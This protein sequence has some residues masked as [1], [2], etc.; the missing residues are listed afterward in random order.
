[1]F[2]VRQSFSGDQ[3]WLSHTKTRPDIGKE[4]ISGKVSIVQYNCLGSC[5]IRTMDHNVP[6][7]RADFSLNCERNSLMTNRRALTVYTALILL[8]AWLGFAPVDCRAEQ[9]E[10]LTDQLDAYITKV[11]DLDIAPGLAVAVVEGSRVVYSK[12]FGYADRERG[13]GVTP[14]TMFYIG[15]TTKSFTAFA[16]LLL[17]HRGVF[18]L[19]KPLSHYLPQVKLHSPLSAEEITI[20]N[21]LTHTH[22][23]DNDGP[24]VFRSALTGEYNRDELM[25]LL[26]VHKP[27][28]TGKSF[29]YGNIGYN[30]AGFAMEA[31]TGLSWK[32]VLHA[33][34]FDPLGLKSTTSYASKVDS[35]S[36]AMPYEIDAVGSRRMAYGK[37]DANMHA[38][39]GHLSTVSDLARWLLVHLNEGL[40]DGRQVFPKEI[41]AESHRLQVVQDRDY[42]RIHR[43]GWALGWDLGV[44]DGDTLIHRFGAFAGFYSHVSF[45][46]SK[47]IGV[48]VLAN[49]ADGGALQVD[50]VASY[51]YDLLRGRP[52]VEVRYDSL[53]SKL[54]TEVTQ[55]R[56]E[57]AQSKAKRAKRSQALSRPLDS[58]QG[59]FR[60]PEYGTMQWRVTN[61]KLVLRMGVLELP[62]EVF[63]A[64]A[65]Q[66]RIDFLG[67]G[68]VAEFTF[69]DGRATSVK[70]QEREFVRINR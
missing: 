3:D 60:N 51:A 19:T 35:S 68:K 18:D 34:I 39:G 45:M 25:T 70:F 63:D 9:I 20:R 56:T 29:K 42:G 50:L 21:L 7:H 48:V 31:A 12:G 67:D 46:P 57:I 15:S 23:L 52:R 11:L 58:Y 2:Q 61:G 49:E 41:I 37:T 16:A 27:S 5:H 6:Q 8:F 65:D 14:E 33:E 1:M 26:S 40:V 28:S 47:H 24:V 10:H 4:H 17:D 43:Y 22:G 32:D 62:V 59:N 36:L 13:R 44:Y 54:Q 64:A 38:A 66:L 53:R 69:D 30:V 55:G